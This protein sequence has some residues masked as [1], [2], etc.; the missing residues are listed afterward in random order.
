MDSIS[1]VAHDKRSTREI[2][3]DTGS[4]A[5]EGAATGT[6]STATPSHYLCWSDVARSELTAP[7]PIPT[8]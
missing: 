4:N 5:A 3:E 7:L 6:A 2:A 1:V 8:A